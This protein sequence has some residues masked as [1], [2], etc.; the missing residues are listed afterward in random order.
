MDTVLDAVVRAALP[1]TDVM[2]AADRVAGGLLDTRL[3]IRDPSGALLAS[4]DDPPGELYSDTEVH[5]LIL[6]EDGQYQIEVQSYDI[7]V[8]GAY[9]LT[10]QTTDLVRP[11]RVLG[12]ELSAGRAI[13]NTVPWTIALSPDRQSVLAGTGRTWS[14]EAPVNP[15]VQWDLET[16]DEAF[17]LNADGRS[18]AASVNAVAFKD[19]DTLLTAGADRQLLQW[20]LQTKQVT[21]RLLGH[22][23]QVSDITVGPSGLRALSASTDKT[24]ILWDLR[25]GQPSLKLEG[26][27]KNVQKVR[28]AAGGT[29]AV[30]TSED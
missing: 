2:T 18:H 11:E 15:I 5:D 9:T 16:G 12:S 24:L 23:D 4:G 6:P 26:H 25:N 14:P 3:I 27:Q 17:R 22:L 21:G 30:S 28:F 7:E 1:A 8:G 29:R 19:E 10:L 20:D 13:S